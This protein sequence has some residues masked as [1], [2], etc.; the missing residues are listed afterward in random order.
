MRAICSPVTSSTTSGSNGADRTCTP[1]SWLSMYEA[2]RSASIRWKFRTRSTKWKRGFTPRSDAISP[3]SRS[4]STSSV[5]CPGEPVQ[6]DAHV[7]DDRRRAGAPLGREEGQ[8][9]SVALT[10]GGVAPAP[11]AHHAAEGVAHPLRFD[12]ALHVLHQPGTHRLQKAGRLELGTHA[13]QRRARASG[14]DR[15]GHPDGALGVVG[16]VDDHDAGAR[17]RGGARAAPGRDTRSGAAISTSTLIGRLPP[18][19]ASN[20]TALRWSSVEISA[21]PSCRASG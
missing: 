4:R 1:D 6:L 9:L 10:L 2:S 13:H 17:P 11:L 19:I 8:Q 18:W 16:H 3:S 7:G 15:A 21:A 5:F 20:T 12:R 14:G